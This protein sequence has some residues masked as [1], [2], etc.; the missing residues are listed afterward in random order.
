MAG[1]QVTRQEAL[2]YDAQALR[3]DIDKRRGNIQIFEDT[4]G[5]EKAAIQNF[6]YIIS[7]IDPQHSD[8]SVIEGNIKKTKA[9]IKT[10]EDAI[11]EE[12]TQIQRDEEMIRIIEKNN[13]TN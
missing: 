8:V 5:K 9:N 11:D 1:N 4:I 10:F 6:T 13:K 7:Q 3:A 12:K 2:Q